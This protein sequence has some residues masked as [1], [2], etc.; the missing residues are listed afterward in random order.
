MNDVYNHIFIITTNRYVDNKYYTQSVISQ[1][2]IT[3]PNV[4]MVEEKAG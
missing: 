3:F 1:P 4:F 2:K